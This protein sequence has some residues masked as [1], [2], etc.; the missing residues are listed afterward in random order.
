MFDRCHYGRKYNDR[1][2][3]LVSS[4][5]CEFL[6]LTALKI[7]TPFEIAVTTKWHPTDHGKIKTPSSTRAKKK[8]N[9]LR[10]SLLTPHA[11]L[12]F[13][14]PLSPARFAVAGPPAVA[15]G[16]D[17][18]FQN[19]PGFVFLI[20]TELLNRDCCSRKLDFEISCQFWC[21]LIETCHPG[22]RFPINFKR[23]W[24]VRFWV[25]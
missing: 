22:L 19:S 25:S 5:Q 10:E 18:G 3:R 13:C 6:M 23:D 1:L 15:K 17:Q 12:S 4:E 9:M 8:K 2:N 11:C 20:N 14:Q 7:G 24:P 16:G 21:L